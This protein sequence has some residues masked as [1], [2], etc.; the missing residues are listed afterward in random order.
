MD[1]KLT[2]AVQGIS[3]KFSST[4]CGHLKERIAVHIATTIFANHLVFLTK[5]Y[6]W[7]DNVHTYIIK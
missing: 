2:T 3:M 4:S 7:G 5:D 6:T 1:N